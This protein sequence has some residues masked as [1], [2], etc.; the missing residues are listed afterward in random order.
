[1]TGS[2]EATSNEDGEARQPTLENYTMMEAFGWYVPADQKHWLRLQRAVAGFKATSIDNPWIS[3]GCKVRARRVRLRHLRP[4]RAGE[5]DQKGG[6]STK[7]G[8]KED[9]VQL[10]R[11]ARDVGVEIYWDAVLNQKAGADR[12]EQC[13]V[14]EVDPN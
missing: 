10:V 5:F 4:V 14:V 12:A 8:I 11:S 9:L 6:V 13:Q 1:M 3:P 7:W 2:A